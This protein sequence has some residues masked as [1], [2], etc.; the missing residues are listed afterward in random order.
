M[1]GYKPG[2][3]GTGEIDGGWSN[4]TRRHC[5]RVTGITVT[6]IT[7]EI[8]DFPP[9]FVLCRILN[10][11][12]LTVYGIRLRNAAKGRPVSDASNDSL[13]IS[14]KAKDV[15]QLSST[16]EQSR[17]ERFNRVR[18]SLEAGTYHVSG[19]EIARKLIEDNTV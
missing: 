17:A 6:E 8:V 11:G 2:S 14:S 19:R 7:A 16:I 1:L 13:S 18:E 5:L 3:L 10:G 4:K 15:E 12:L 9:G